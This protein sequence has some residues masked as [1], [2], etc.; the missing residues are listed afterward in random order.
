[1]KSILRVASLAAVSLSVAIT[2]ALTGCAIQGQVVATSTPDASGAPAGFE[3]YYG[4]TVEW[5]SC[6][7]RLQ[8]ANVA[9]P[10]N[11][12]DPTS[13]PISLAIN[14]HMA[15]QQPAL[16]NLVMNPG[17][18]GE[19]AVE[20]VRTSVD[21]AVD[22]RL[23]EDF[24][25]VGVDPRGV[26]ESTNVTCFT[27]PADLDNALYGIP[28]GDRGSDEWNADVTSATTA[29]GQA[30][31]ENTG[32]LLAHVDTP[33]VARDMDMIRAVMGD[34]KL[35]FLGYSYGTFVGAT[36]ADLFPERV[37]RMVLDG[38]IDPTVSSD[39]GLYGQVISFESALDAYLAWCVTGG[40]CPLG[41][42]V[43]EAGTALKVM[44][45]DVDANPIQNADGRLLGGDTL[46][47]GL[48][49]PLYDD[50]AWPQLSDIIAATLDGD[51]APAFDSADAYNGRAPDGTYDNSTDAFF[52]INCVD[53][54]PTSDATSSRFSE[55][56]LR[57][58]PI[59]GPYLSGSIDGCANWPVP[60]RG[61]LD[62]I[63]AVGAP[64]ILIIGTTND[65]ATPYDSAVSLSKQMVSSHLVTLDGEGHTAYNRG[66]ACID[67][68][69]D[70]YFLTGAIPADGVLCK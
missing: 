37:G 65:P 62:P 31:L 30:C 33:S 26:G 14:R 4:Q 49:W 15:Q 68:I 6:G 42:S 7:D 51:P 20:F 63:R 54:P 23:R 21:R 57:D 58:A 56:L 5:T 24:N 13:E 53:S 43:V 19:S 10:T 48:L 18:P 3:S 64:D 40:D 38:A 16:G 11:W 32:A 34:E 70:A 29:F 67:D 2:V 41:D 27:D 35:N 50:A 66:I 12:E 52:A 28:S 39:E 69:V 55:Q 59:L 17:G 46:V 36:Y 9:A 1:M 45:A 44:L 47:T 8:C 25:I 22:A 61:S 60:L